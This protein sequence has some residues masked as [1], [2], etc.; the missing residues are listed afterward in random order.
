MIPPG[1]GRPVAFTALRRVHGGTGPAL[2]KISLAEGP[3]VR[4]GKARGDRRAIVAEFRVAVLGAS[5]AAAEGGR[6]RSAHLADL[7]ASSPARGEADQST[8]SL[9][10]RARVG[11]GP[12]QRTRRKD[13]VLLIVHD[14]F[15]PAIPRSGCSPALPVS[16]SPA[17]PS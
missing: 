2:G 3:C 12:S 13:R 5:S 1:N 17:G 16:A 8:S 9:S 11:P 10:L 14:E 7:E 6:P 15:R 4:E